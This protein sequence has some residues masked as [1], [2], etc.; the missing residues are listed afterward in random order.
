MAL[1]QKVALVTGGNK[2]IGF[3]IAKKL[4]A[5]GSNIKTIIGCRNVDLGEAAAKELQSAGCDV[6]FRQLD[7]CDPSSIE[8]VRASIEKDFGGLDILVN[9]AAIAFKGSDPTP[10]KEQA[11]P[12]VMVNFF[13]TLDVTRAM[14]PLLRKS[15]TARIIN[16]ASMT[17]HLRILPSEGTKA[18]FTSPTLKVEELESLMREFVTDVEAGTHSKNGWPN[19]CYGMSKLSVIALTKVIARNE[20]KIIEAQ[21]GGLIALDTLKRATE[22][23][24]R[25]VG[26]VIKVLVWARLPER[27]KRIQEREG[28]VLKAIK[29]ATR[30]REEKDL[31]YWKSLY[32]WM[33]DIN[34]LEKGAR[35]AEGKR[36]YEYE[37]D[38]SDKNP[39]AVQQELHDFLLNVGAVE[40]KKNL[41]LGYDNSELN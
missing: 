1:H 27:V 2:G 24:L 11:R 22:G 9:N 8:S 40:E 18:K 12:T 39:Q 36:I 13:G 7:I 25:P 29:A 34:P 41:F 35:D 4:G 14:L 16:V 6:V 21:L 38:S 3:Q 15:P 26:P 20:P 33:G 23:N 17:G 32:E 10:F 19:T 31:A 28:G 37:I 5:N 30:N